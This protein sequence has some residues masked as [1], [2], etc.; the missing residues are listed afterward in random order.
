MKTISRK[1]IQEA[2]NGKKYY[3]FNVN[4][5]VF[6]KGEAILATSKTWEINYKVD[7]VGEQFETEDG[8]FRRAYLNL[9]SENRI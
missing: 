9:V 8:T 7:G 1:S 4:S 6:E 3:E 5:K 2:K